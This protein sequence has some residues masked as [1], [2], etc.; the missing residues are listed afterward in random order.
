VSFPVPPVSPA[1][2]PP[3]RGLRRVLIGLAVVFALVSAGATWAAHIYGPPFG[4]YLVPP[5]AE[6][7]GQVAVEYLDQGYYATGPEWDTARDGLLQAAAEAETYADLHEE[8]AAATLVA[9]GTHSRFL[10]PDEAAARVTSS[11]EEYIAPTLTT[12]GGTTTIVLPPLGSVPDELQQDYA[13][14]IADGIAGAPPNTCRWIVDLRGNTGGNMYP[15]LSGVTALLPNGPAFSFRTRTGLTPSVDVHDDGVGVGGTTV[16]VGEQAKIAG[17]PIAV[18]QDTMTASSGEAVA[19]A[20]RGLDKVESFGTNS[21]GYTSGNSSRT[22]F[23]GAEVILT[24]SV[25]V[26]RNGVNLKEE[27]LTPDHLTTTEAAHEQ[28]EQ[29]LQQQNCPR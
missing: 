14:T 1:P 7:Y 10:N 21:Y 11:I 12:D 9:G 27:P 2:R 3:H 4:F 5:S 22:L 20:F 19:T 8:I 18:L 28:A 17:E 26:D 13:R 25:Y 23:D 6:R 29:W 15:M 16:S 24:E